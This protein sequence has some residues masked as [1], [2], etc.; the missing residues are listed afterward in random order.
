MGWKPKYHGSILG[1]G[2]RFLSLVMCPDWLSGHTQA[3]VE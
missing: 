2:K 1:R 3:A